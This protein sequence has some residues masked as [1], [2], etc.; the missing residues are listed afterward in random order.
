MVFYVFIAKIHGNC[1]AGVW[2]KA[3]EKIGWPTSGHLW[4]ACPQIHVEQMAKCPINPFFSGQLSVSARKRVWDSISA[5]SNL[6]RSSVSTVST[7]FRKFFTQRA[8]RPWHCCP[9]GCGCPIPGGAQ[10]WVGWA[11]GSLTWWGAP[12]PQQGVGLDGL[13]IFFQPK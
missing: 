2:N 6:D 3:C 12:S 13:Y 7:L 4:K 8:G 10:G 11:L 1:T 9:K 5:P